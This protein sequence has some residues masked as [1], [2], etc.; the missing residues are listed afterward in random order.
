M[1]FRLAEDERVRLPVIVNM[2]GF[3]LS[4]TREPVELPEAG[5]VDSFL[6]PFD[7]ETI[8]FRASV[9]TSQAVAVLGGSPYS[10]FRYETHL[11]AMNG[12]EVYDEI[13]KIFAE[14]FGRIYERLSS[15]TGQ[16]MRI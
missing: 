5:V 15:P 1:A 6:P 12:L 3:Y 2:D 16:R 10:Y 9:P 7:P 11:A 4:F 14:R 8:A 13:S